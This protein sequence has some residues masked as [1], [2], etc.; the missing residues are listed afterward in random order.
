MSTQRNKA[1][2]ANACGIAHIMRAGWFR[3]AHI[4]TDLLMAMT[5]SGR[6]PLPFRMARGSFLCAQ[7]AHT[8]GLFRHLLLSF[9]RR[10]QCAGE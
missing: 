2:A 5:S 9:W 1:D 8:P 7:Y 4:K 6:A 10:I 3:G